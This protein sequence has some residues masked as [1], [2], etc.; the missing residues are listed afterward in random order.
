MAKT[1]TQRQICKE[2]AVNTGVS[3]RKVQEV[4]TAYH[5]LMRDAILNDE[6]FIIPRLGKFQLKKLAAMDCRNPRTGDTIHCPE[7]VKIAFSQS[8]R[9]GDEINGRT[10]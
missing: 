9:L 4:L 8:V 10:A 1:M 5:D 2:V 6:K 3:A 7:R